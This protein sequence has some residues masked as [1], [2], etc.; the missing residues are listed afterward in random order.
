MTFLGKVFV[1]VNLVI[2]LMMATVAMGLYASNI[3]RSDKKGGD[4][5]AVAQRKTALKEATDSIAP[6][7]QGW[8]EA[9]AELTRREGNRQEDQAWYAAELEHNRTKANKDNPARAVAFGDNGLPLI[10][11]VTKRR[12]ARVPAVDRNG[13]PLD[14][15]AKYDGYLIAA[16]KANATALAQLDKAFLADTR[17]ANRLVPPPG[18][19]GGLRAAIEAER[20]KQQGLAEESASVEHLGTKAEVEGAV[21]NDRIA[22]LDEQIKSLRRTLA[23][24]KG[25]ALDGTK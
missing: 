10:D 3:D 14:A 23:R 9:N 6:V 7:E 20:I 1:M 25:K 15:L 5:P 17:L 11:P 4:T 13:Q 22:A 18:E 24:L 12:P 16:Q 19:K 8:S 21:I 2:S